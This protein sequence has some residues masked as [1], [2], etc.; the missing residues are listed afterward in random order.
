ML[1]HLDSSFAQFNESPKNETLQIPINSRNLQSLQ[2]E[3]T[4]STPIL[5]SFTWIS[6]SSDV[7][8][9]P[10]DS[11]QCIITNVLNPN[12]IDVYNYFYGLPI[13]FQGN[14]STII[15][16]DNTTNVITCQDNIFS[17]YYFENIGTNDSNL[18]EFI[19]SCEIL[20]P[21]FSKNEGEF[22]LLGTDYETISSD[23][24]VE[25]V[26]KRWTSTIQS[27]NPTYVILEDKSLSYDVTDRFLVYRQDS[28]Y[29]NS[30]IPSSPSPS[31]SR[32]LR[33]LQYT[34]GEVVS[35]VVDNNRTLYGFEVNQ[36]SSFSETSHYLSLLP[37]I[38]NGDPSLDFFIVKVD[39]EGSIIYVTD[40]LTTLSINLQDYTP[41]VT[42]YESIRCN[43][44]LNINML[45][46]Y[47]SLRLK[48]KSLMLPLNLFSESIINKN[49]PVFCPYIFLKINDIKNKDFAFNSTSESYSMVAFPCKE[50]DSQ[51]Y[52][53]YTSDQELIIQGTQDLRDKF[54]VSL[55]NTNHEKIS[56]LLKESQIAGTRWIR[57]YDPTKSV[58]FIFELLV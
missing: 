42:K 52:I 17:S 58:T 15:Q 1:I 40:D 39:R 18:D 36:V 54:N 50:N 14:Y 5:M 44:D 9:I 43:L 38:Q 24:I 41:V 29:K 10:I 56:L 51:Q 48:L 8:I 26:T 2:D 33:S 55:Y 35:L 21:S 47:T 32:T 28:N 22:F 19:V 34:T 30:V 53:T 12:I 20:N 4:T 37:T 27:V 16:F 25:N 46:S 3:Y 31:G 49:T 45:H 11:N 57:F 6:N 23:M 7:S 13:I